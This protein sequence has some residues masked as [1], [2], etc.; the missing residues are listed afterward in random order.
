MY[1][2]QLY[3]W[4]E[5]AGALKPGAACFEIGPGTGQATAPVLARGAASLL[6]L[7]PDPALAA[8][9]RAAIP[10]TRLDVRCE[11]F[12]ASDPPEGAF[13]FGFAATSFHWLPRGKALA[14]ARRLLKPGG[15]LAL[16]WNIY[17]DPR[18]P[19]AFGRATEHLFEGV[20][21]IL[22]PDRTPFGLDAP[23]RTGEMRSAGFADVRHAVFTQTVD[24]DPN[25][26]A[27]L[28]A[29]F[30]RVAKAPPA[31]RER[32]LSEARRI[33]AEDFGG[34]VRRPIA[35]GAYLGRRPK[36]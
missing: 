33:A 32:L 26:M 24:F 18:E 7:E 19:D 8:H 14:K 36:P 12:E 16:W 25:G 5:E 30:S 13:D 9:L 6:A 29:T 3:A 17:H 4:L 23:A 1:K 35:C 20:E 28:F 21:Q 15:W 34:R 10:D 27:A 22:A 11:T 31:R 2:R